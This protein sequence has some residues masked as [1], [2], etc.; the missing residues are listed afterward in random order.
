MER[1]NRG[2]RLTGPGLP[3]RPLQQYQGNGTWEGG[4]R[5]W[6]DVCMSMMA[7]RSLEQRG[8]RMER[9]NR[10]VRLTGPGIAASTTSAIPR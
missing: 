6:G 8:G 9:S 10:G 3:H 4:G 2:V 7:T 5:G 1:S